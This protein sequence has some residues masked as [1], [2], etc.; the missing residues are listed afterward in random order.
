[1]ISRA[2]V[3]HSRAWVIAAVIL[4]AGADAQAQRGRPPTRPQPPTAA[5]QPS[6]VKL[7]LEPCGDCARV[8]RRR[9][10]VMPVDVGALAK[11]LELP[12]RDVADRVRKALEESVATL[13]SLIVVNRGD[14]DLVLSE[15]AFGASPVANTELAAAKGK[16]I[17]AQFLLAA[18]VN[19]LDLSSKNTRV[20]DDEGPRLRRQADELDPEAARWRGRATELRTQ[21]DNRE[22]YFQTQKS[23]FDRMQIQ[24]YTDIASRVNSNAC[25]IAMAMANEIDKV[26]AE[27]PGLRAECSS[28]ERQATQLTSEVR[29]FEIVQRPLKR[30]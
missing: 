23:N 13:P 22:R 24:C 11:E 30:K 4:A 28:A 29:E 19:R 5:P 3:R 9:L 14:I 16:L 2:P 20:A 15:Q 1:M 7:T 17:P 12:S 18:N 27:L 26:G 6:I 25:G 8:I 21:L 10:A